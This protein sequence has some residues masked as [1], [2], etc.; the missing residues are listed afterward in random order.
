MQRST[1]NEA[2]FIKT[3][4]GQRA[5]R[6]AAS[7]VAVA[8][9]GTMPWMA[10]QST[11]AQDA[12]AA[13]EA[14]N[15]S[16]V[17]STRTAAREAMS[18][19]DWKKAIDL[20]SSLL[21]AAPGDAEASKGMARAQ[22]ALDQGALI[23][24]V[25]SDLALRKQKAEVEVNASL[26]SA[27][28]SVS[29]GDFTAAKR[30]ALS[31]KIRLER[32]K[33]IFPGSEYSGLMGKL[34]AVLEQAE[35]GE[36]NAALAKA[37]AARREAADAARE[38]QKSD[39]EARTKAINE[40]L[41]RV[42]QL[43]LELKYDEAIQ[44]VDEILF[45]DPNNPAAQTLRQMLK[46]SQLYREYS[47]IEG[48]RSEAYANFSKEAL[49]RSV[50]PTP[51]VTGAG[52]KSVSS[53]LE[54]P[55]DWPAL[56]ERR[57]R[58]PA[59]GFREAGANRAAM[60]AM[61]KPVSVNF[62]GNELGQVFSYMSQV[63]GVDFHPD[64]KSLESLG[65][66]NSDK[67]TL[68][69]DNVPAE[70]AL[71]RVIEQLGDQS[72]RPDY[73][74]E[75]GIVVV[76]S[77]D[78]LRQKRLTIVYD[79]RDLIFEVPYF[80]NAPKFNLG[81]ASR[82]I[83]R[84]RANSDSS[85][86]ASG[87]GFGEAETG[88]ERGADP[89]E[90][91]TRTELVDQ[92]KSVIMDNIDPE[93]WM[94]STGEGPGRIQELN[95]NLIITNTARNHRDIEGL[96]TQLR[97]I[98]ALQINYEARVIGVTSDWFEQIGIDLDLYFNTNDGMF[99]QARG[100]DP[101]FNLSDFFIQ[102]GDAQGQVKDPVIFGPVDRDPTTAIGNTDAP[103]FGVPN[104]DGTDITYVYGP[105]GSPIRRSDGWRPIGFTQNSIGVMDT[106][107]GTAVG[108][109]I[110]QQIVSN[111]LAAATTGFSYMDD[112]Q[113]DLLIQ[114][115]QADQRNV[116]L[117]APRLTLMN[118]QRSFITIAKQIAY[119][120]NVVPVVGDASTSFQAVPD[121]VQ[122]GF[123]LDIEGV[124]SADRRYV[125]MTVHFDTSTLLK[126]DSAS[127]SGAVGG[128]GTT[129]GRGASS[130]ATIQLPQMQ[131]QSIRTTVSVPDKGTILLGGQR[132]LT[133]VELESGVP[134]LSKIPIVNRFFT[135]RLDSEQELTLVMLMRPE[136]VI[137]SENE[138]ILF[139]GLVDQLSNIGG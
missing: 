92:I 45:L 47:E 63:S 31:A 55:E 38:K 122:D 86:F 119:I 106:L 3:N 133:E 131:V 137:Q 24:D 112:I 114:A 41:L 89:S 30:A 20:W 19:S 105:V 14:S 85:V 1:T 13:G 104:D 118:G 117:T 36:A 80:D 69:L 96:L 76:S 128:T 65:V 83:E 98:R 134:V 39:A 108:E 77:E 116:V 11:L 21:A 102:S 50:P 2:T 78:Q 4:A 67:V 90:R 126:F 84:V 103:P 100:V 8:L 99:Q 73:A 46:A 58:D 34:D 28:N 48:R 37:E 44:V 120:S 71:K 15:A 97:A 16:Q 93:H 49:E 68:T 52:P 66:T 130:E 74:V 136:I 135:N 91:K 32:E 70:V 51:N 61:Q 35:V 27:T 75:D 72:G 23:S 107:A 62:N 5:I 64:W 40:R 29:T 124:V 17:D 110:G 7:V 33:S 6:A 95:G 79:I 18:R 43:Q 54:Y 25:G 138:E 10:S 60:I 42:R 57:L 26:A 129:G 127:I 53:L 82:Q 111:G 94:E 109:G 132:R 139:P 9:V 125:T 12:P 115:T 56:S 81:A 59:T 88:A 121:Y 101:N 87:S 22:A 123:V 113:V